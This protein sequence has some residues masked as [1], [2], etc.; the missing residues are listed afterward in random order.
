MKE[1]AV[2]KGDTFICIGTVE[3]CAN[4]LDVS[5]QTIRFYLSPA[6]KK[7]I[8][9]RGETSNSLTVIKIEDD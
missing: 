3:E 6:Y 7:R 2:Y 1:Y 8:A 5:P 4:Y 9:K